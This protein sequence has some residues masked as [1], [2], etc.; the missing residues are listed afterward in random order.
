[1]KVVGTVDAPSEKIRCGPAS[2]WDKHH[3]HDLDVQFNPKRVVFFDKV[4]HVPPG[5]W[6]PEI[7]DSILEELSADWCSS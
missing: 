7:I 3:L 1:M 4:L 2:S 6:T 5:E